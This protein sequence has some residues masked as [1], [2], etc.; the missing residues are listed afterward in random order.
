MF[1]ERTSYRSIGVCQRDAEASRCIEADD[2]AEQSL[3]LGSEA[4][5]VDRKVAEFVKTAGK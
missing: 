4:A 1:S 3:D 5:L 2:L